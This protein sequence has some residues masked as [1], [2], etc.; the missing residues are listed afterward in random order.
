M[1]SYMKK[2]RLIY[3]GYETFAPYI[4]TKSMI[5]ASKEIIQYFPLISWNQLF[6]IK[7]WRLAFYILGFKEV[8]TQLKLQ[9]LYRKQS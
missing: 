6:L 3:L 9:I 7:N 2:S 4:S 5:I 8:S 1:F